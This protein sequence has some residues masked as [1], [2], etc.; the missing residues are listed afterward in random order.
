MRNDLRG[1]GDGNST[2]GFRRRRHLMHG[3]FAFDRIAFADRP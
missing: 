3:K 2:S 1:F